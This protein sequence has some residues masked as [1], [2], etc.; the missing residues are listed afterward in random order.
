MDPTYRA[1]DLIPASGTD[2]LEIT[3]TTSRRLALEHAV[4]VCLGRT[5][6]PECVLQAA[7]AFEKFLAGA[8]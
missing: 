2:E 5:T 4:R 1:F 7:R 8:E 6:D 3:D